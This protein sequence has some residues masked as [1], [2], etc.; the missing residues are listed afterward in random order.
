[1]LIFNTPIY[2]PSGGL[3]IGTFLTSQQGDTF[4]ELRQKNRKKLLQKPCE[5]MFY[6]SEVEADRHVG[7]PGTV[8]R[9]EALVLG[10]PRNPP[11]EEKS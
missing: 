3:I 4:I 10:E 7:L 8:L 1:M 5:I 9:Y 6:A 2:P 11:L